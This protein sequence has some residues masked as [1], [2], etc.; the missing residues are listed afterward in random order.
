MLLYLKRLC[1]ILKLVLYIVQ[2]TSDRLVL[3]MNCVFTFRL[4]SLKFD[5]LYF[6][7][8]NHCYSYQSL[9]NYQ[10]KCFFYEEL[11]YQ[12]C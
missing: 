11:N 2:Y 8:F 1:Q 9:D 4:V 6:C 12:W 3:S 5:H 7:M 10:I